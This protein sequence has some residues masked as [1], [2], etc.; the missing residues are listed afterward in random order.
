MEAGVSEAHIL[1]RCSGSS[2]IFLSNQ[3]MIKII[4]KG[5]SSQGGSGSCP[6]VHN[7]TLLAAGASAFIGNPL[8]IKNIFDPEK[9][10][11]IGCEEYGFPCFK[12]SPHLYPP[13]FK[14]LSGYCLHT[15]FP[16]T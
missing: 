3:N 4:F 9:Q 15:P 16:S 7:C 1:K 11:H 6:A 5:R 10:F 2:L 12:E 13:L 14:A 8:F